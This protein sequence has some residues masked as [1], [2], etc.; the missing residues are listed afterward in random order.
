MKQ[1]VVQRLKL[2]AVLS[3]GLAV[4]A[5]DGAGGGGGGNANSGINSLGADFVRAFSQRRNDTPFDAQEISLKLTPMK[6]PFNP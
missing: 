3:G 5:C 4:A 2:V 1:R 6:A